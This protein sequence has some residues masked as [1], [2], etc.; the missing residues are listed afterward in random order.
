MKRSAMRGRWSGWATSR[1]SLRSIRATAKAPP[2]ACD[3]AR[4]ANEVRRGKHICGLISI[5]RII[6]LYS[7][8]YSAT[9]VQSWRLHVSPYGSNAQD[10]TRQRL[11]RKYA[12]D[13]P[14]VP[15]GNSQG[16]Q[17]V[18]E[19]LAEATERLAY[20]IRVCIIVGVGRKHRRIRQQ[21]VD[22][23]V[24]LRRRP[25]FRPVWHR[26]QPAGARPRSQ[27]MIRETSL[28]TREEAHDGA[29]WI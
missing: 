18:R 4:S 24:R 7:Y 12:P 19:Q 20:V 23:D 2:P 14:R 1:I 13:Q 27:S 9:G 26:P 16:G 11:A 8:K 10:S 28:S 6:I 3:G 5:S 15:A 17:G 25:I 22:R 21:N 29:Q